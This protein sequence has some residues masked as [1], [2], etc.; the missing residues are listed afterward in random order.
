MCSNWTG[1]VVVGYSE[2]WNA[3]VYFH[4]SEAIAYYRGL[5]AWSTRR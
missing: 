1:E 3:V 4:G 5:D 2:E